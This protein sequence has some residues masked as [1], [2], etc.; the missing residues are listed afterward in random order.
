MGLFGSDG[1]LFLLVG[2]WY[3]TEWFML[4]KIRGL[5]RAADR[6]RGGDLNA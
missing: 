5:L 1:Q 2:V 6:M 4:R 3:G